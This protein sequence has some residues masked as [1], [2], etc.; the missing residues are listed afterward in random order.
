MVGQMM[1]EINEMES[2]LDKFVLTPPEQTEKAKLLAEKAGDTV[3]LLDVQFRYT[4]F[5]VFLFLYFFLIL[6]AGSSF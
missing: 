1:E 3:C 4:V 5:S 6:S 2:M